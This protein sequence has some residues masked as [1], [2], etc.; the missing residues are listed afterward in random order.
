MTTKGS[1]RGIRRALEYV[2]PFADP[3][4]TWPYQQINNAESTRA[5]LAYLLRRAA[6]ALR[7]PQ[8]QRLLEQYLAGEA[9]RRHWQLLWLQ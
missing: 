6:I 9:A 4:Q 1:W 3:A 7:E 2:A 5:D 8:Y